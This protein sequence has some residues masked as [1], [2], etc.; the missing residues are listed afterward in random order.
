M[1][2]NSQPRWMLLLVGLFLSLS[3]VPGCSQQ[4]AVDDPPVPNLGEEHQP[5]GEQALL[6]HPEDGETGSTMAGSQA[7]GDPGT[8][9]SSE[10]DK[11]S[12]KSWP[13]PGLAIVITG[14]QHGYLEPCGCTGLDYQKGGL[15][16]RQELIRQLREDQKWPLLL[17]DAGNQVRRFGRQPEIKF[18]LTVERLK[19]IGYQAIA[20]GPDDLRL[21][22]G[23]LVAS[24]VE[25]EPGK[26]Q[27]VSANVSVIDPDLMPTFRVVSVGKYRVGITSVLG[28][29]RQQGIIS[30]D[31]VLRPAAESLDTVVRQLETENCD[32]YLLLVQASM[33]ETRALARQF[34]LFSYIITS[35]GVG[36]PP[37][38]PEPVD[39]IRGT[40]I[41]VGPKGMFVG[42]L[43][44]YP[45][46]AVPWRYSS[47]GL[48]AS[49]PDSD[50]V[51]EQLKLYQKELERA[52]LE[53]LGI[54]PVA[55]SSGAS[56]VGSRACAKCHLKAYTIWSDS[57]HAQATDV[58]VHPG[59]RAEIPRHHDPECLSCH[60]T[61]WNPQKYYPYKSGYLSLEATPLLL[62]NGCEN[63]HG[64]GSLHVAAESGEIDVDQQ[65]R[66]A[67][68][69]SIRLT[70][71]RAK[72]EHCYQCHDLDNSPD[73]HVEGAFEDYWE[74]IAH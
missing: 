44:L 30:D 40:I 67:L 37:P 52:G 36:D 49:F 65:G 34:P 57:P 22:A 25:E 35:A 33:A 61:G 14:R 23:E 58:L 5:G 38:L 6:Q 9:E 7:G 19:E 20:L 45:D 13:T 17:V 28:D 42:V 47:I 73:F 55:H 8:G 41:E 16:R 1:N 70:L 60:V 66:L 31:L 26:G 39:G 11:Q 10:T 43:G 69:F 71:E 51:L 63:C 29:Q 21:P 50:V 74:Q 53:G 59:E 56:F 54:R 2:Y 4:S 12:F 18:Q 3:V 62:G 27:F 24:I 32:F 46:E 68:Q 48:D 15:A 64:P 72:E